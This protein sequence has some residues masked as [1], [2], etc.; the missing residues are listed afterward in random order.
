MRLFWIFLG[1]AVLFTIPFLIWGD[2]MEVAFSIEGAA[3]WL[4][5]FESWG[6]AAGVS[7]L[8]LDFILPI[9]GTAVM[10]ALGYV[11]GPILGGL[12]ASAGSFLAGLFAYGL[13][14]LMGPGVARK[15]LGEKDYDRGTTLFAN[16]GGW[17]IVISRWLPLLPEVVACMAGLTRMPFIKFITALAC[18]SIPLG[19]V[20]AYIGSTG[21]QN[22]PMAIVLSVGIPPMLWLIAQH[23]L[24]NTSN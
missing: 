2:A 1:L 21:N 17:I 5:G 13:C 9:P 18:G 11:Y 4:Q 16:V 15:L 3:Q 24:R 22:P 12:I 14:R 19:F 8:F 23:F 20:F 7:L 6:W 10:S